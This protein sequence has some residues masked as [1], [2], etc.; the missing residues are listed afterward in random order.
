M[1]QIGNQF[2]CNGGGAC[3]NDAGQQTGQE[4]LLLSKRI[5][6]KRTRS[7]TEANIEKSILAVKRTKSVRDTNR[8]RRFYV[9]QRDG[10]ERSP[11]FVTENP[12]RGASAHRGRGIFEREATIFAGSA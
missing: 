9:K 11:V 4:N 3:A 5:N 6:D 2:G 8:H 1:I 12:V 10:G 7:V